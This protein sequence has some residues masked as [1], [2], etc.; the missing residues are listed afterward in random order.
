M[1]QT[2]VSEYC[3]T[4]LSAQSWQYRDRR[5]PK[6]GTMPYSY[7]MTSR[8]LYSAQCY[9]QHCTLHTFEQVKHCTYTTPLINIRPG[10]EPSITE[11]RATTRPNEPSAPAMYKKNIAFLCSTRDR[12]VTTNTHSVWRKRETIRPTSNG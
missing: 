12:F 1:Y 11:F 5:K 3:F 10:F 6:I 2:R 4:S 8:V 9:R 7:R